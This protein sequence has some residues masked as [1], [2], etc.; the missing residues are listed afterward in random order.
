MRKQE[1]SPY[2]IRKAIA[3]LVSV[4][5]GL[6]FMVEQLEYEFGYDSTYKKFH[7]MMRGQMEHEFGYDATYK[8]FHRSMCQLV[9]QGELIRQSKNRYQLTD[10]GML[11]VLPMIKPHL[12]KDGLMRVLVFDV[13]EDRRLLRDRFRRHINLLGFQMHQKSVWV[14]KYD[15]EKWLLKIADYHGVKNYVSLYIG[16]HIW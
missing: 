13:P 7:R 5:G 9:N 12:A 6:A 14:S 16:E 4:V 1:I 3:G 15:C 10:K 2:K 11:K 8:K